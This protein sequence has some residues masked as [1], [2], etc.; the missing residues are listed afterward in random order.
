MSEGGRELD[1]DSILRSFQPL[2][3]LL[4]GQLSGIDVVCGGIDTEQTETGAFDG[5]H[6]PTCTV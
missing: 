1:I 2:S 4:N 3:F 5:A 6:G